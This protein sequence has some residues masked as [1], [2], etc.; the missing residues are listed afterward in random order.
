MNTKS[1][2]IDLF[3]TL[4][5]RFV[6]IV[7]RSEVACADNIRGSSALSAIAR[8]AWEVT[9]TSDNATKSLKITKSNYEY[10]EGVSFLPTPYV[11]P[12]RILS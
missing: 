9:A 1:K 6:F 2:T 8:V 11:Q 3:S 4:H 7:E 12:I 10:P 5:S